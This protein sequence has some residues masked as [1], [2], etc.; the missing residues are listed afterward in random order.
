MVPIVKSLP[1][2]IKD[3]NH[4]LEIFRDFNFYGENKLIFTMDI[5]SLYTVISNNEGLQALRFFFDQRTIKE[6][7]SETLLRLAELVLTLKCFSFA[8]NH[9]KKV[10]GVA[11]G[12]KMGPSYAKL[13]VGYIENQFFNQFNGTKPDLYG[14]YIDDCVGAT[15]S[16][17]E[18]LH[19]F[20][21]SVNSFHPA[22]K[23]SWEI[24]R[25][26]NCLFLTPKFQSIW[27]RP[28]HQCA[29]QTYRFPQLFVAFIL[30]SFPRQ[31]LYPVLSMQFLRL[32]RLCSDDS[33]FSNKS[34]EM[35]HFFKKRGYP[36]SV[37]NTAQ[38]RAQIAQIDRQSA[39]QT[40]QKEKNER[41]P[42][43]LTYHPHNLTSQPKTS[44]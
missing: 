14:H 44:F 8:D 10:N 33:D 12:T 18:E 42:F 17:R 38:H 7:S 5:T 41:I 43:T 25:N 23:Y 13:F 3:T 27:Q 4:A 36:D 37:V 32:R 39:L 28:V 11:M 31:K 19:H 21:T 35:R 30:S 24:F 9:Y 26:F 15:S 6:P 40:S 34:E 1:S 20:I 2:Y 22:L 29:V 16:S